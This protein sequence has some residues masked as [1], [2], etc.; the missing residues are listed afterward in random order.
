MDEPVESDAPLLTFYRFID[1][2]RL[3]QRAD[4]SAGGSI[5]TRGL[6]R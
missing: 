4:R 2:A 1:E 6:S 5:P 3:P